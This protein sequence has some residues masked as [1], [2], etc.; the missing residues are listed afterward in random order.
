MAISGLEKD[1]YNW[2]NDNGVKPQKA[3]W[4]DRVKQLDDESNGVRFRSEILSYRELWDLYVGGASEEP[5]AEQESRGKKKTKIDLISQVVPIK[6]FE[7]PG[8]FNH[9][10]KY[11]TGKWG[12]LHFDQW[13]YARDRARK[14]LYWLCAEVFDMDLQPHVHQIV[15]DQFVTKN[16]D[17]VYREGYRLK[18]DFQAAL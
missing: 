10:G 5:S 7:L 6:A 1:K 18:E 12:Y 15:C 2:V 13:L 11:H 9:K 16:F 8:R 17:G 3:F 4:P 14:D